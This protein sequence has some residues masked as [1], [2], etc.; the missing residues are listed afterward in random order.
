LSYKDMVVKAE[1]ILGDKLE[2]EKLSS[3]KFVVMYMNFNTS[4]PP[5]GDTE[6]EALV[7]FLEWHKGVK[8]EDGAD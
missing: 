8:N 4:P 6:E 2:I 5:V 3:G 7:K 1:N